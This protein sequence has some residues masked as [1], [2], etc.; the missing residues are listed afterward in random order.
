[1]TVWDTPAGIGASLEHT[2]RWQMDTQI[3]K[4]KDSFRYKFHTFLVNIFLL[5]FFILGFVI[6]KK[7]NFDIV[8]KPVAFQGTFNDIMCLL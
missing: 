5:G 3:S 1:M 4:I 8:L 6:F 2:D 7:Q